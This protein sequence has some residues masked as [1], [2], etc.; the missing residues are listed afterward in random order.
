[1]T[2]NRQQLCDFENIVECVVIWDSESVIKVCWF[3]VFLLRFWKNLFFTSIFRYVWLCRYTVQCFKNQS[4]WHL[5]LPQETPLVK[6]Q[7]NFATITYNII[8]NVMNNGSWRQHF[9]ASSI[10]S[11][12]HMFAT[13]H[14]KVYQLI[15]C[16]TFCFNAVLV[17]TWL[18]FG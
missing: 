11:P 15:Y 1:M 17:C 8:T 3:L 4:L 2:E 7:S 16:D 12:C 14:C 18:L 13:I 10:F 5:V 6:I 9:Y